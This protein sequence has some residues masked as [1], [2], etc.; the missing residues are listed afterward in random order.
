MAL[1]RQR[2]LY[3]SSNGD[4]WA[5]GLN[6]EGTLVVI[7]EPNRASGGKRS[8]ITIGEFLEADHYGPEHEALLTL[9]L[10]K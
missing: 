4:V 6:D 2:L 7:H 10:E 5:T 9:I 8:D 1:T 3:R